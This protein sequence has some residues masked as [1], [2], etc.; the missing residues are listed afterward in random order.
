MADARR[1]RS[2]RRRRVITASV[3]IGVALCLA[4]GGGAWAALRPHGPSFRVA[5]AE[6]GDVTQTASLAGTVASATRADRAFQVSGTVSAV[7]VKVG[8]K[9]TAGQT[10]ATLDTSMLNDT[11][12]QSQQSVTT[13]QQKLNDDLASQTGST[14]SS[15]TTASAASTTD[16]DSDGLAL[17]TFV[18]AAAPSGSTDLSA[19]IAAVQSAQSALIDL[20]TGSSGVE[21]LTADA[22]GQLTALQT[23]LTG[24]GASTECAAFANDQDVSQASTD[25]T[26]CKSQVAAA[27]AAA[28]TGGASPSTSSALTQLTTDLTALSD[29]STKI[30]DAKTTLDDAVTK[31]QNDANAVATSTPT[32]P[33]QGS[34][35]SSGSGSGSG[36][37]NGPSSGS[38]KAPS[39][40]GEGTSG[41]SGSSDSKSNGASRSGS[42][43]SGATGTSGKTTTPASAEQIVADQASLASAQANLAVAQQ[44]VSLATLTSPIAGTVAAVGVS[45]G[46]SVTAKSTSQVISVIGDSGWIVDTAVTAT[47][48]GPLKVGQSATVNVSG[49]SG[50]L[51]GK[52]TAIGFLNTATDSSTPSYDVTLALA[53]SGSGLLNGASARLT[54]DVAKASAVLTVPSSAV[55]LGAGNTYSVDVLAGG[56]AVARQ[57]KVGAIGS[58]RTQITSG[59]SAGDQVILAD[60]SS[61]VSSDSTQTGTGRFG[62]GATGGLG[63]ARTFG[64]GTGGL[65]GGGFGGGQ[66]VEPKIG[67]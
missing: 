67:G 39:G 29:L 64:G 54:V 5:S 22:Q 63:G 56:K 50:A 35:P 55:H 16:A 43:S 51:T 17:G 23:A 4:G 34:Q 46:S 15:S 45:A 24:L 3:A 33:A 6:K 44:N 48:L 2:T 11:V 7:D 19:D 40:S 53:G 37:G 28:A 25:L 41:M 62:G 27:L 47:A 1:M 38:G 8:D 58:D 36:S 9:V 32:Q 65:G 52:V 42:G 57:V 20:F 13:A 49:V 59:L 21:A 30:D 26:T 10:L 12:T 61:T 18:A 14:T 66:R 31:L 60:L